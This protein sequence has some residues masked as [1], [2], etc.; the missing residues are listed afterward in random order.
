MARLSAAIWLLTLAVGQAQEDPEPA[1]PLAIAFD[2]F[3]AAPTRVKESVLRE[4]AEALDASEDPGVQRVAALIQRAR[5]ELKIQNAAPPRFRDPRDYAPLQPAR[6]FLDAGSTNA[7]NKAAEFYRYGSESL[8]IGRVRYDFALNVGIDLGTEI[9][10]EDQLW[11]YFNGYLPGSDVLIAWLE[12]QLD[13]RDDLDEIGEHFSFC[14]A[15]LEGTT[16]P[17]ITLYDAFSSFDGVDMPDV[18]VIAYAHHILQ[19]D[20]FVSPIPPG[21]NQQELYALVHDGFLRYYRHR[22]F[23]EYVANLFLNPE[24]PIG[25]DHEAIRD[26]VMYAFALDEMNVQKIRHRLLTCDTRGGFVQAI[27][28]LTETDAAWRVKGNRVTSELNRMRWEVAGAAYTVLR[29]HHFLRDGGDP[30]GTLTPEED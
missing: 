23:V 20:S 15:T 25:Y 17:N 12:H 29:R 27:D 28:R 3:V 24:S 10:P 2:E 21:A 16:Y 9:A 18:D 6:T 19:D 1:D 4:I 11:N 7:L 5:R 13:H 14:F 26:R 30:S 8:S 22:T